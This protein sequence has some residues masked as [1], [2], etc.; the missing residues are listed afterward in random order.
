MA[1]EILI[2]D[3]DRVIR[4]LLTLH[5]TTAGYQVRVAEDA[6][7][8]GRMIL[9]STPDLLLVDVEMPYMSGF[10]LVATLLADQTL[11]YIPVIFL[12]S[13]EGI[14]ERVD[15]LGARLLLKPCRSDGLLK[16]V[17]RCLTEAGSVHPAVLQAAA[18]AAS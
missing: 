16:M 17:E 18:L 11:P 14:E 5:L 8:A 13:K 3:D 12:T 15:A 9:G 4:E 10:Q 6:L 1:A 2:V 7:V